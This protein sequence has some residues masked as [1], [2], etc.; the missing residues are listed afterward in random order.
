MAKIPGLAQNLF[1][2]K[3]IDSDG[4]ELELMSSNLEPYNVPESHAYGNCRLVT[5]FDK[6]SYIG[7]GSYGSVF[8]C[9]DKKYDLIVAL[10]KLRVTSE[11]ERKI[12]FHVLCS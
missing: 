7:E 1:E 3:D 11:D 9:R 2:D 8:K 12:L 4:V 6:L 5:D 10:K